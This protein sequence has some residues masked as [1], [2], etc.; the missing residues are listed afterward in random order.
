MFDTEQF[1]V[2]LLDYEL[3]TMLLHHSWSCDKTKGEEGETCLELL[4][5]WRLKTRPLV[6]PSG[7]PVGLR[8]WP[9]DRVRANWNEQGL[10]G[11]GTSH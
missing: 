5:A 7:S 6:D 2:E 1:W 9:L 3:R 11:P 4:E 10:N 8:L